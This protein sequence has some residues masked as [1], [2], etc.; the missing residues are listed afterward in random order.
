[1]R[2]QGDLRMRNVIF[3]VL[4]LVVAAPAHAQN[5][6]EAVTGLVTCLNNETGKVAALTSE[7]ASDL[8]DIVVYRCTTGEISRAA[9]LRMLPA[10]MMA[11]DRIVRWRTGDKAPIVAPPVTP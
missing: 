7:P 2:Q 6:Q 1:M 9:I 10:R 11:M 5:A 3:G 8:S 4:A